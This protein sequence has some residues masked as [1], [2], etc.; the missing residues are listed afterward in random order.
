MQEIRR[1]KGIYER[2]FKRPL[3][4]LV[5]IL[6]LIIISPLLIVVALLIKLDSKGPV[7]F[8]QERLGYNQEVFEIIKFRT[9]VVNAEKIGTGIVVQGENDPRITGLGNF[10]RRTSLDELPQFINI[11]KGDMALIGPRPPVTY[12]PYKRGEYDNRRKHRFDV[13]PGISGLAQ[14]EIRNGGTWDERI[15]YDLKYV[16]HV[17]LWGDIEII[18]DTIK[19]V[20]NS[21]SVYRNR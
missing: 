7:F 9:M 5:A 6:T 4:F 13:R 15:E 21:K 18:L 3:G 1:R 14:A 8:L 11:V 16:E 10:L 2:F 19:I 20:L 12:H 17:T